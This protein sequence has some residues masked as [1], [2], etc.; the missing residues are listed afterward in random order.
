MLPL[1]FALT[2]AQAP[3]WKLTYERSN[4]LETGRYQEALD[5][6]N[7]LDEASEDAKVIRWGT[8]PQGRPLIAL[9]IS[10]ERAFTDDQ[11]EESDKPLVMVNNGIHSG[12]IEGKDAS[13]ILAREIL[14]EGKHKKI[15]DGINLVIIPV[16]SADAHERFGPHNRVNQNG[17]KEMGWR[18]TAQNLNLN[19][20]FTKLQAGE[21]QSLVPFLKHWMPD[22]F[23]DNH[24][25]DGSDHQYVVMLGI[26]MAPTLTPPLA[27]WSRDLYTHLEATLPK[28][29]FL[30]SPYFDMADRKDP[31]KG[32]SVGDFS[33]RFTSGYFPARN[34]PSILVETHVLKPYKQRVE[35]TYWTMVRAIDKVIEDAP[36]L[37]AMNR[38][39]DDA[40]R[41]AKEGDKV[42]LTAETLPDTRPYTFKGYPYTGYQSDITGGEISRWDTSK[43]Q[44]FQTTIRDGFGPG[45]TLSLPAAYA[46]PPEW[47]EVYDL[48]WLHGPKPRVLTEPFEVEAEVY[49][50]SEVR[51][52]TASFEG[53][54]Q[55]QFKATLVKEK[56]VLPAGTYI[57]P[58]NQV[59]S[60]LLAHLLEPEAPDSL[61]RWG[62]FNAVLESKEYAEDYAMEPLAREMLKDPKLKAEFEERLKDEAFAK[63]PRARLQ[64]FYERSPYFDK[65]LNA[66][67]VVRLS[68][69]QLKSAKLR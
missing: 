47:A 6:C 54:L 49:R 29:G 17:P 25:T 16:F 66:Y 59:G 52:G 12:E 22:L 11:I 53:R 4:F 39:A 1:I 57:Y 42:V 37:K 20:D 55:P 51:F 14:I 9:V 15:L 67:P 19:R 38:A 26:P 60:K 61:M 58:V 5:F 7:R 46:L 44:D 65:V 36:A 50:F 68:A 34:R 43:P 45:L 28:D 41:N 27:K 30:T 18:A 69:E 31:M 13:L 63:N 56:R 32:I 35:A 3:D 10:K 23:F 2:T 33:P 24:T 8:S 48:I 21:T 64:F 40:E 62:F